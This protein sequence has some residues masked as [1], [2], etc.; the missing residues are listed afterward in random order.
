MLADSGYQTILPD[1]LLAYL[2]TDAT[3]PP[4]PIML[5]F[6]VTDLDQYTVAA[7]EME[8]YGFKGVFFVM[9]VPL[10]RPRYNPGA[11]KSLI[12]GRPRNCFP[13]LESPEC[14]EIYR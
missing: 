1:Q 7:P 4:K 3:L 14:K 9:A 11:G 13:Y 6:D 10:R 12:R 2:E 5:T 8:K